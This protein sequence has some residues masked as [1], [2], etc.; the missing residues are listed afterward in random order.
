MESFGQIIS[1]ER[2]KRRYTLKDVAS[3][4][5]TVDLKPISVPYLDNLENELRK[6]SPAMV[7]QFSELFGVSADLLFATLGLLSPDVLADVESKE[8][9]LTALQAFRQAL[10]QPS[11]QESAQIAVYTFVR[12]DGSMLL[13]EYDRTGDPRLGQMIR[14]M[15]RNPMVKGE[16][17][18][19]R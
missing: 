8:H 10:A 13:E 2:K 12:P 19:K 17:R 6:P 16:L 14:S 4:I 1:S 9:L 3:H 11:E 5:L 7:Q 18:G 15:V